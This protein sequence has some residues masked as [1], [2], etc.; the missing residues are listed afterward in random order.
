MKM[1]KR[2]L[3]GV[4]PLFLLTFSLFANTAQAMTAYPA[5]ET[6]ADVPCAL[7]TVDVSGGEVKISSRIWEL[8]FGKAKQARNIP[9][10]LL[11]YSGGDIFGARIK[12]S[13]VTVCDPCEAPELRSGDIILSINGSK[14]S[15]TADIKAIVKEL[16]GEPIKI[17]V[18]RGGETLSCRITAKAE[19]GEYK[20][21][22]G[23]RDSAAG[24]GTI[25]YIDPETGAF[26]GLGHGICD[27]DSGEVI[28]IVGGSVTGVILGGV[29]KGE[30]GKPGEL[31]G[32]LTDR[33]LGSVCSN[34]PCGIFGVLDEI[35][36]DCTEAIEVGTRDEIHEGEAKIISTLKNGKKGEYTIKISEIDKSSTGTKSFKIEVTDP[37]LLAISGG[38]VRGMSGSP[39][40]QDGK[41]IGAVTHVMINDPTEGYGIFIEN[42]LN[43]AQNQVIPK[44]A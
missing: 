14:V 27:S 39:I 26:G 36:E 11:L 37:A 9:K 15:S 5:E 42:M 4:L 35:P 8:F 16:G 28:D 10:T 20:L 32:I 41:L 31:T 33:K 12:Q 44:A 7:S 1:M 2:I 3:L 22:I 40:I 19:G 6:E 43:A 30:A 21:N 13:Y 29:H 24:I 23:L 25:T 38:I 34:T 18:R 17:T